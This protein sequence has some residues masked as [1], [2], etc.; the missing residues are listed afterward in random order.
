MEIE[1]INSVSYQ[2]AVGVAIVSAVFC[3]FIAVLLGAN[4]YHAKVTDPA[5][6]LELEAMKEQAKANPADQK[7]AEAILA[8]DLSL[9]RD[10]F[11]RQ[12]FI[13]RG[14]ILLIVTVV[15]LA[16]S[17]LW[18]KSREPI[19]PE[20]EPAGDVKLRQIQQAGRVRMAFTVV[21]IGLF[22]AALYWGLGG[23][24]KYIAESGQEG[25]VISLYATMDEME[26]QWP[27]FR[28]PG[29]L[30]ICRFDAV[31]DTWDGPSGEGILWKTAIPLPGHNSPVVWKDRIFLTGATHDQQQ[32]Y[33]FDVKSGDLLW[34][35]E[36]SIP[37]STEHDTLEIMEDTGYA[38]C[39]AV[40][41][42]RRVC[43]IFAGG[44][45]GCFTMR[46]DKL[47]EKHLGIPDSMYGYA[48]SLTWFENLVIIQ[49]D[50]GYDHGEESP[51][52]LMAVDWQTGNTVW[53]TQRPVPN[54]WPSPTV[55]KI[56]DQ[57]QVLT[58]GYPYMIAYD[59]RTGAELYRAACT[60]G[61]IAATPIAAD[62]RIFV[63]EPYNK[64]VAIKAEGASGDVTETH[65]LWEASNQMPDICSP[66]SNGPRVWTL[67]SSGNLSCFNTSDGS[68]VYTHSFDLSFQA[69]PSLIDER[70]YLLAENGT[71]VIIGTG[72]AVQEFRRNALG[73]RCYASPAF[74]AGRI[75]IRAKD[76]LYAIGTAE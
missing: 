7:L 60:E 46:G 17:I 56:G 41:D 52:K 32:V 28:G 38:A 3:V 73:E 18:A 76:H 33:C 43:A 36:V 75:Y 16:G 66:L 53:Q 35:G 24:S 57:Y 23:G 45:M 29:G 59:P 14:T 20:L 27:V 42:G 2:S 34:T 67:I 8:E 30:G 61:D 68:E 48:A 19:V 50:V 6:A 40:T 51:S 11:A 10:Q 74:S 39:T 15:L 70:M 71:M 12:Y 22:G 25:P 4:V 49:W 1:K 5:R 37:P 65:I 72:D 55:V 63:I 26:Q 64:L 62:G 69:S 21:V 31:P 47:W 44:D 13:W 58:S 9:R 54:S